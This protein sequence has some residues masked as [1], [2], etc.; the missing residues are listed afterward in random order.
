MKDLL[1]ETFLGKTLRLVS[2]KRLLLYP[3]EYSSF[4]IPEAY[5]VN[6]ESVPDTPADAK[7]LN[8]ARESKD[9]EIGLKG[10]ETF[11]MQNRADEKAGEYTIVDCE[12]TY[13]P[14]NYAQSRTGYGPNDPENPRNWSFGKKSFVTGVLCLLTCAVYGGSSIITAVSLGARALRNAESDYRDG[15][16]SYSNFSWPTETQCRWSL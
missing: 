14:L 9:E 2:G 1:R 15:L 3:E 8:Y 5:K 13:W 10:A 6:P 11:E 16:R 7:A 4:I 12:S